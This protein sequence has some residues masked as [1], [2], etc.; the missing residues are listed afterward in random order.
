MRAMCSAMLTLEAIILALAIPAMIGV[1]HVDKSLAFPI[2]GGLAILC[3]LTAGMLRKP[4]AYWLG[5][6]TQ[7]A[8]IAMGLLIP[9]M[10][11]VGVMF[12][13]LWAGAFFLGRRIESDKAAWAAAA[14][15]NPD[16][17]VETDG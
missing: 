5:H 17:T 15:R 8:A 12:A 11:F 1:G 14:A 9:V 3:V 16:L 6:L 10:F 13:L 2:G 7:V 4:W